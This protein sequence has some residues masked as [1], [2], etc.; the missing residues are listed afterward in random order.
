MCPL[1]AGQ[2]PRAAP[3][4]PLRSSAGSKALPVPPAPGA[5]GSHPPSAACPLALPLRTRKGFILNSALM[6]LRTRKVFV[7]IRAMST[8]RQCGTQRGLL[9]PG[10]VQPKLVATWESTFLLQVCAPAS[11]GRHPA[12]GEMQV[13]PCCVSLL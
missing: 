10:V 5:F 6:G 9:P 8:T 1:L 13:M 3:P 12:L 2:R 7:T 4:Q 11:R